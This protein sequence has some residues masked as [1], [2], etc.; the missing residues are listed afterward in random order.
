MIKSRLS[1]IR[2][3]GIGLTCLYGISL[4]VYLINFLQMG[5]DAR[6]MILTGFFVILVIGSIAL[7][8]LQEWG[9]SLVVITNLIMGLFLLKPYLTK[10]L[11]PLSY[12]LMNFII[13][14]FFSQSKIRALFKPIKKPNFKSILVIDDDQTQLLTIRHILINE[15]FSVLAASTGEEG[16][17]IVKKQKP[18]LV[19][20]DVILPGIKGREV[21]KK[22]K[23]EEDTKNILVVFL[24]AKSS[25]D[26]I[27]AEKEVGAAAHLTKPV[28]ARLLLTTVKDVLKQTANPA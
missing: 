4:F 13:F 25:P 11:I 16:L 20:L 5:A 10:D 21:C 24:T 19:I 8:N 17:Q 27:A 12:I 14:L 15:G 23:S 9:R 1:E 18:D 28:N 6:S 7:I 3:I 2:L 26:D 22:I